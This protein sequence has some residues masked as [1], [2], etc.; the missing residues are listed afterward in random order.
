MAYLQLKQFRKQFGAV[1]TIKGVK[2]AIPQVPAPG[3]AS[4]STITIRPWTCRR[5]GT[6]LASAPTRTVSG[7]S[8][9][10]VRSGAAPKSAPCVK[11]AWSCRS[12][13]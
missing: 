11:R 5:P 8:L 3:S 6:P 7:W 1:E 12:N 4:R 13:C 10:Q 9:V 2:A